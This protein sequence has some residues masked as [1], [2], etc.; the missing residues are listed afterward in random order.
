[1]SLVE[2]DDVIQ[3]IA[4]NG[5]NQ[6]L[7]VWGLPGGARCDLDFFH[8]QR[9]GPAPEVQ[10]VNAIAVTEQIFRG[11]GEGKSFAELLAGPTGRRALGDIEVEDSA[12]IV[13]EDDETVEHLEGKSDTWS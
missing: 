2:H 13:G 5:T 3:A 11:R 7:N 12:A 4:S 8:A 1:M 6:P 10:P 9:F